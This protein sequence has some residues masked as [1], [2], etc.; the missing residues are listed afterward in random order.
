MLDT[1]L[2]FEGRNC[3]LSLEGKL[4]KLLM[5]HLPTSLLVTYFMAFHC[6]VVL[7]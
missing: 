6:A 7:L 2:S 4:I 1:E 3:L 5:M